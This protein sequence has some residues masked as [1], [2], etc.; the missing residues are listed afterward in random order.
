MV[1]IEVYINCIRLPMVA[2]CSCSCPLGSYG[3]LTCLDGVHVFSSSCPMCFQGVLMLS[4]SVLLFAYGCM[5]CPYGFAICSY[6]R[7]MLSYF[8]VYVLVIVK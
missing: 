3:V 7:P 2:M 8:V 4:Y 1:V 5:M 6:G